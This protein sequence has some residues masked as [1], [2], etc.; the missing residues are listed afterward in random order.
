MNKLLAKAAIGLATAVGAVAFAASSNAGVIYT[1]DVAFDIRTVLEPNGSGGYT[2]VYSI[3]PT[4]G[5]V[6]DDFYN[7]G[8]QS[9][10][11]ASGDKYS[12]VVFAGTISF[13]TSL[14]TVVNE[15]PDG[16]GN[17]GGPA[18]GYAITSFSGSVYDFIT[19]FAATGSGGV[20]V[21]AGSNLL[22]SFSL[23]PTST[24]NINNANNLMFLTD[25]VGGFCDLAID[26]SGITTLLNPDVNI[27]GI[28]GD[29]LTANNNTSEV[30]F[31]A[32]STLEYGTAVNKSG[33][34]AKGFEGN[35]LTYF[36]ANPV[37]V[38]EPGSLAIVGVGLAGLGFFIRRRRQV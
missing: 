23:L 10:S 31:A 25:C 3:S 20:G 11:V 18:T 37:Q 12:D 13:N 8:G 32:L 36:F 9:A 17:G 14:P 2:N 28:I 29:G 19:G 26:V 27:G 16:F 4:D 24:P 38:P 1:M 21:A 6:N 15:S 22:G 35:D 7:F 30:N 34:P 33:G 5:T